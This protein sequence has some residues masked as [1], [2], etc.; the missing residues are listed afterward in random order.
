M[1]FVS[2][3]TCS[4]SEIM[5]VCGGAIEPLFPESKLGTASLLS[6]ADDLRFVVDGILKIDSGTGDNFDSL[7]PS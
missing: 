5:G 2:I 6:I 4:V 7:E 3:S 1:K